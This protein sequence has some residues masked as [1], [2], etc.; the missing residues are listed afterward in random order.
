MDS[1]VMAQVC[2]GMLL[3]VLLSAVFA[4]SPVNAWAGERGN[5]GTEYVIPITVESG[6]WARGAGD[7][8][9]GTIPAKTLS[10]LPDAGWQIDST[11]IRLLSSDSATDVP[12]RMSMDDGR[13][14]RLAVQL[15]TELPALSSVQYSLH[16]RQTP[17]QPSQTKEVSSSGKTIQWPDDDFELLQG[18]NGGFE[19]G[20]TAEATGWT[21]IRAETCT[22]DP[23]SG[24]RCIRLTKTAEDPK[25][26]MVISEAF[27][28]PPDCRYTLKVRCRGDKIGEEG[29]LIAASFYFLDADKRTVKSKP[30]RVHFGSYDLPGTWTAMSASEA[31]P[32]E[33][34]HGQVRISIWK[35]LGTLWVDDIEVT[36]PVSSQI[37]PAIIRFGPATTTARMSHE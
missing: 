11:S 2:R 27:P 26:P 6:F 23:H 35:A 13:P 9:A 15:L 36:R 30:F 34:R 32:P 37:A 28:I 5:R 22:K 24:R 25:Y 7:I 3:S 33:T 20:G 31:A 29:S 12:F 17:G 21:L 18:R 10:R 8:V 1:S 14:A 4:L 16:V 19:E